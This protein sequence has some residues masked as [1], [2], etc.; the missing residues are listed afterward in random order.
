MDEI[1]DR[2]KKLQREIE[3]A[4]T[5]ARPL[6]T[7]VRLDAERVTVT[8]ELPQGQTAMSGDGASLHLPGAQPL[9]AS[10]P[11]GRVTIEFRVHQAET[12]E[13]IQVSSPETAPNRTSANPLRRLI[14]EAGTAVFGPG[15][16]DN[17]ARAEVFC[18]LVSAMPQTAVVAALGVIE[19]DSNGAGDVALERP[20][21]RLRQ[22]LSFSPL[23]TECAAGRLRAV[24][25]QTSIN[26]V[27]SVL[28]E[29]WRFGTHWPLPAVD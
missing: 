10:A 27:A 13:T 28:G 22:L 24:I 5:H 26:E 23:G 20:V 4:L 19:G 25:Q 11:G 1:G 9:T 12:V 16:F 8:W 2:I 15:G 3:S 21:A 6:P 7:G 18:E 17:S 29:E 14:L